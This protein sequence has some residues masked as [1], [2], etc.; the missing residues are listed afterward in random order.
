MITAAFRKYTTKKKKEIITGSKIILSQVL[1]LPNSEINEIIFLISQIDKIKNS[2]SS[3]GEYQR[4]D[5]AI[6]LRGI[7]RKY[8]N[9]IFLL[10]ICDEYTSTK[11]SII[12]SID[13]IELSKIHSK[14]QTLM[15]FIHAQKLES[16]SDLK[17]LID[18]KTL[19]TTLN[20]KEGKTL[21][22]LL[23][24]LIKYQIM[25]DAVTKESAIEYLHTKIN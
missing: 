4:L 11:S 6:L 18:G 15:T 10:C 3:N 21:G 22:L 20:I 13:E 8:L 7:K 17:P 24:E 25:N 2:I 23:D 9:A 14:Y 16:I 1:K 19:K 5:I 12:S